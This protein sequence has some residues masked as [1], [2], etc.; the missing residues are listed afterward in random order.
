MFFY[1][2]KMGFSVLFFRK[3]A[4]WNWYCILVVKYLQDCPLL[5][6]PCFPYSFPLTPYF[7]YLLHS[8]TA[9]TYSSYHA[10]NNLSACLDLTL[11]NHV[12]QHY[13]IHKK[14][15]QKRVMAWLIIVIIK[16]NPS[17]KGISLFLCLYLFESPCLT[18]TYPFRWEESSISEW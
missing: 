10:G 13:F 14:Q 16:I 9:S 17:V 1:N 8:P 3:I 18:C 12:I 11:K 6:T 7:V 15:F 2:I 5:V 4:K